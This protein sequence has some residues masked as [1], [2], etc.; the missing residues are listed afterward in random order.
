MAF[1]NSSFNAIIYSFRNRKYREAFKAILFKKSPMPARG[2][3]RTTAHLSAYRKTSGNVRQASYVLKPMTS[4]ELSQLTNSSKMQ[5]TDSEGSSH[6]VTGSEQSLNSINS[7]TTE[8][9]T[10][11][12]TLNC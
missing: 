7:A 12:Q 11:I 5:V 4:H 9:S 6:G 3:A 2:T 10:K 1:C 8:L